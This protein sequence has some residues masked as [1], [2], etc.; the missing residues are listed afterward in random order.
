M[1]VR[2]SA[3][4]DFTTSLQLPAVACSMCLWTHEKKTFFSFQ[5]LTRSGGVG[6]GRAFFARR[7]AGEAP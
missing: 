4:A 1:T 2:P 6:Q 5:R 3:F 7:V